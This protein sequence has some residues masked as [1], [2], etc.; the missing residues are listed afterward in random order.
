[1]SKYNKSKWCCTLETILED[2]ELISIKDIGD[3]LS[4]LVNTNISKRKHL[5][6]SPHQ[7]QPQILRSKHISHNSVEKLEKEM[8]SGGLH[9]QLQRSKHISRNSVEKLE[10]E[11]LSGGL[12]PQLQR[13]K[14]S[15][16]NFVQ[17]LEKEMQSS[18]ITTFQSWLFF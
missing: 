3:Q 11:M 9:P 7:L 17:K 13:S 6:G 14:H 1:M 2:T 18:T 15:S 16:H 10:K 5:K 8:S 12:Q 4:T